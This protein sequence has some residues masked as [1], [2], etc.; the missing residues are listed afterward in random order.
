MYAVI[1][2][3]VLIAMRKQWTYYF[4][5][6]CAAIMFIRILLVQYRDGS[7]YTS[8]MWNASSMTTIP[9]S[10]KNHRLFR[11]CTNCSEVVRSVE[12]INFIVVI[13][14]DEVYMYIFCTIDSEFEKKI[15]TY[16]I[17]A[18]ITW[19]KFLA[20]EVKDSYKTRSY[21]RAFLGQNTK[22]AG[23]AH[24]RTVPRRHQELLFQYTI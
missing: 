21:H 7:V 17:M 11:G 20:Y 13:C 14:Y 4:V 19:N 16:N 6:P 1:Q 3:N 8:T 12:W 24:D 9:F 23:C 22:Y 10:K 2:Y 5:K 15:T 18:N